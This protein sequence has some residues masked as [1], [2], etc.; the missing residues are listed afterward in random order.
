MYSSRQ[1]QHHQNI[2]AVSSLPT[3]L[4]SRIFSYLHFPMDP[5]PISSL[6]TKVI[7]DLLDS[8]HLP[9]TPSGR[10]LPASSGTGSHPAWLVQVVLR[11]TR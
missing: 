2:P 9:G 10:S 6:P 5:T 1:I 4:I 3:E 7:D 8:F 11:F